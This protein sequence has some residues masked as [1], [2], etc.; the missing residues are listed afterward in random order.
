MVQGTAHIAPFRAYSDS[1]RLV[2]IIFCRDCKLIELSVRCDPC[3]SLRNGH[4][5][6]T[7][8]ACRSAQMRYFAHLAT[9][10][11]VEYHA[12][13]AFPGFRA[14]VNAKVDPIVQTVKSILKHK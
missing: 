2:N 8:Y 11:D 5:L 3:T 13:E 9:A 14:N 7:R 4:R 10:L 1:V 6:L 12:V